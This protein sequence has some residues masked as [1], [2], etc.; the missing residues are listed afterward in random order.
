MT[1]STVSIRDPKDNK[2]DKYNYN[3]CFW[4]HDSENGRTLFTN[5]DLFDSIGN[6]ILNNSWEGFNSTVFAYGQTGSGKSYSIE[7]CKSDTGLLQQMC[8]ALYQKK[9]KIESE[10]EENELKV[11]ISYLEVYNEKLRDLLDTDDGK[12]LK[13]YATKKQGIFVKNLNKIYCGDFAQVE[14]LLN[15]GK[16]MRVV[17]STQMNK[18]SSR[19]HAVFTIYTN[20]KIVEDGGKKKIKSSQINVVDLAGNW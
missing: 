5:K 1:S 19:S 17:G 15:D 8:E 7:G 14:K 2:E 3:K 6:E 12:K 20:L 16:K 13:I 10:G 9:T 18:Q 4:S 11:T